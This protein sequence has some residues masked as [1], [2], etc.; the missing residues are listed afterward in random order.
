MRAPHTPVALSTTLTTLVTITLL[1][2]LAGCSGPSTAAAPAIA[3]RDPYVKAAFK[4]GPMPMSAIF[5]V[6]TNASDQPVTLVR[7]TSDAANTVELRETVMRNGSVEMQQREGGFVVPPRGEL[8]LEPGG[9]H[10]MLIGLRRDIRA[11]EPVSATLT[12]ADGEQLTIEAEGRDVSDANE[13]SNPGDATGDG[14]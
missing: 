11:G 8:A 4:E 12:T 6:L 3:I 14:W 2:L 7:G 1:T 5:G 9:L 10:V 13:S